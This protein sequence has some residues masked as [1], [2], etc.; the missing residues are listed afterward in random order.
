MRGALTDPAF[1]TQY[2]PGFAVDVEPNTGGVFKLVY[3]DGRV[4]VIGKVA[5][6]SPPRRL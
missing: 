2:F 1:N 6:W 4:H 3:S 5:D